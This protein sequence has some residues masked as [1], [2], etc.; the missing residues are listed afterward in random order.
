MDPLAEGDRVNHDR[1]G[2]GTVIQTYGE[3]AVVVD[4]GPAV[5][6]I[7]LPDAKLIKL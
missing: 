4:F 7:N 5:R 6:R 2:L 3:A 1:H